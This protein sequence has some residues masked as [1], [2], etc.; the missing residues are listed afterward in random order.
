MLLL[1]KG[2]RTGGKG[3]QK[4][5][6]NNAI[7]RQESI[8][9]SNPSIIHPK[10]KTATVVAPTDNVNSNDVIGGRKT[11]NS[12]VLLGPNGEECAVL[13]FDDTDDVPNETFSLTT[14]ELSDDEEEE[15]EDLEFVEESDGDD[16]GK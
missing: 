15:E 7:K 4:H 13:I 2:G 16:E 6:E 14:V 10:M 9:K 1:L 8:V 5:H 12:V 11:C 3:C